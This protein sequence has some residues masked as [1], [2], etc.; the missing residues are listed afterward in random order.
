[1]FADHLLEIFDHLERYVVSFVSEIHERARVG[2][3]FRNN[4]L[5][6]G[7]RVNLRRRR[8]FTGCENATQRRC[9]KRS[10]DW[11]RF[12]IKHQTSS[13]ELPATLAPAR[14]RCVRVCP[15]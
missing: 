9:Y 13:L 10:D 3:M 6:R 11:T 2:P 15:N 12:K 1:M 8:L 5:Y 14:W 4:D 7:V